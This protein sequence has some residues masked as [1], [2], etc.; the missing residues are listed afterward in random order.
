MSVLH[1]MRVTDGVFL[2]E[3]M[4]DRIGTK[5][6]QVHHGEDRG[7]DVV[8]P[9]PESI[10]EEDDLQLVEVNRAHLGNFVVQSQDGLSSLMQWGVGIVTVVQCLF[11]QEKLC[12][13]TEFFMTK[14]EFLENEVGCGQGFDCNEIGLGDAAKNEGM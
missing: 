10:N 13:G 3:T 11:D 9:V 14:A 6:R 8:K 1:D 2:V 7:L 5:V 12:M 4:E